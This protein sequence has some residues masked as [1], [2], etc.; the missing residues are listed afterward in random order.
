MSSTL[1][2]SGQAISDSNLLGVYSGLF[3]NTLNSTIQDNDDSINSTRTRDGFN[4]PTN[5][6]IGHNRLGLYLG[7]TLKHLIEG[8][9]YLQKHLVS[10]GNISDASYPAGASLNDLN[11]LFS[12]IEQVLD[13]GYDAVY[14]N[15]LRGGITEP[16]I[17]NTIFA[18][19][20]YLNNWKTNYGLLG[21]TYTSNFKTKFV[22]LFDFGL[23][24]ICKNLF[25]SLSSLLLLPPSLLLS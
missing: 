20:W 14:H 8:Y 2:A 7:N 24:Q 17:A 21:K 22:N 9:E 3:E 18:Y 5:W 4:V 15:L 10:R 19:G 6:Y 16:E 11:T 23:K 13:E 1:A 25:N 12:W